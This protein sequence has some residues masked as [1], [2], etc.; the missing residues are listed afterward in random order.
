MAHHAY[1]FVGSRAQGIAAARA[2]AA[3]ALG[4]AG[5]DHPDIAVLEFGLFSVADARRLTMLAAQSPVAG[6]VRCLIVAAGRLFHEAQNALL[7]LFE[8]PPEGTTLILVV[9]TEGILLPTLRS[10]LIALPLRE[11]RE[12][13]DAAAVFLAAGKEAREKQVAKLVARSRSDKDAEKQAARLEAV[14][15][16]AGIMMRLRA[17]ETHESGSHAALADLTRLA[18]LLHDRSAP[19]KLI[20]EHLLLVIPPSA[21]K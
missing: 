10:R 4:I 15:L 8:E 18:P 6:D 1:L 13:D 11:A 16:V 3:S 2:H 20:F 9:P 19:L 21:P 12:Q 17:Q 14:S 7:K 5:G